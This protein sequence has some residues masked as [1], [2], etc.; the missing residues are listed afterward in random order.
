[1]GRSVVLGERE[2][3]EGSEEEGAGSNERVTVREEVVWEGDAVWG[4]LEEEDAVWG[5]SEE[6]GGSLRFDEDVSGYVP[7]SG[8]SGAEVV[9]GDGA[10]EGSAGGGRGAGVA[11]ELGGGPEGVLANWPFF[12]RSGG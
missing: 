11:R 6:E 8:S 12:L 7:G 2:R 9:L 10:D 5:G 4:G 3:E 1:M